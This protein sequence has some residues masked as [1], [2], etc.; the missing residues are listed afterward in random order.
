LALSVRRLSADWQRRYGHAVGLAETF[1]AQDR[2]AGTAYQAAGWLWLGQT[3]GRTRQD[4]D[5]TL[6]APIKSVWV[7]PLQANFREPLCHL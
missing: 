7:K 5:R 6:Q 4:R 1:V 3:T 2:F